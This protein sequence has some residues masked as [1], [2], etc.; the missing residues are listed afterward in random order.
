MSCSLCGGLMVVRAR[1]M[2][3]FCPKCDRHV[4]PKCKTPEVTGRAAACG[5]CHTRIP[6]IN[7]TSS[8]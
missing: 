6:R 8:S 4:C 7:P 3:A 5:E 1:P 2:A